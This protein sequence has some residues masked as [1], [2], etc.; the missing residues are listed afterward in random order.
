MKTKIDWGFQSS[1]LIVFLA[2]CYGGWDF[3]TSLPDGREPLGL[4][5]TLLGATIAFCV[6][7]PLLHWVGRLRDGC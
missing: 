4:L 7:A 1:L 2:G 6:F 3:I 5:P